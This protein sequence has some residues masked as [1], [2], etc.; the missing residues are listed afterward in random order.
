M[1]YHKAGEK[2]ADHF[3]FVQVHAEQAQS[4]VGPVHD[5]P[6]H[7]SHPTWDLRDR[8]L[9]NVALQNQMEQQLFRAIQVDIR[10]LRRLRSNIGPGL[11]CLTF[12]KRYV[13]LIDPRGVADVA[14]RNVE[15]ARCPQSIPSDLL[16]LSVCDK[17]MNG[18][19]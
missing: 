14:K 2:I 10:P 4:P 15:Y 9:L 19:R 8:Y 6:K 3:V 17:P 1:A 18:L 11:S 16:D 13:D 5:D 7:G 12:M